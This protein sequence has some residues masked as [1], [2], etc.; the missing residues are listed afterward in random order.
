MSNISRPW[1]FH[2]SLVFLYH[3]CVCSSLEKNYINIFNLGWLSWWF[4]CLPSICCGD[5]TKAPTTAVIHEE[6]SASGVGS[7][8]VTPDAGVDGTM[9]CFIY[10]VH[11]S[12][13]FIFS[14]A[15]DV[16]TW[17]AERPRFQ[18]SQWLL[19]VQAR[20]RRG[21]FA[22]RNRLLFVKILHGR[23]ERPV[24]SRSCEPELVGQPW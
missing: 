2:S 20:S 3:H 5:D 6:G 11:W 22:G 1:F 24:I 14:T 23:M 9:S 4:F 12:R 7:A 10:R 16:T 8:Q 17:M 19:C 15:I 13:V 21:R 18:G